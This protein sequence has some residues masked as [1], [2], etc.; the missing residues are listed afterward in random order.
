MPSLDDNLNQSTLCEVPPGAPSWVTTELIE[1]TLKIWQ[2]FYA[3]T[4][5]PDDALE[6]ILS[7]DRM[8]DFVSRGLRNDSEEIRRISESEQP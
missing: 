4:L 5:I 7:V 3:K 1:Q 6:M 2:P 8:F